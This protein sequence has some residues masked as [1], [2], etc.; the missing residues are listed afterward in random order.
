MRPAVVEQW[1][2][3]DQECATRLLRQVRKS[4]VDVATCGGG[5][6]FDVLADGCSRRARICNKGVRHLIAR[7]DEHAKARRC[8]QQ[9]V[10]QPEPLFL[11][12]HLHGINASDVAAWSVETGHKTNLDRIGASSE[13]DRNGRGCRFYCEGR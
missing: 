9:F 1:I 10:Q 2:G 13:H 11:R 4:R 6:H 12:L 5:E 3:A 8:R 7:I